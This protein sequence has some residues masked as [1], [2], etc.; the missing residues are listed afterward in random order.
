MAKM[1]TDRMF[2]EIEGLLAIP[3]DKIFDALEAGI[4]PVISSVKNKGKEMG[5]YAT[6]QT[7]SSLKP[8]KPKYDEK[9]GTYKISGEFTGTRKKKNKNG[10]TVR[11]SEVAFINEFGNGYKAARP[12]V[13]EGNAEAA[14][15]AARIISDK[16]YG[17][18]G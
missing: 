16:L 14:D 4:E 5:V 12:F 2:E 1:K 13:A 9:R 7:L 17:G 8:K 6:G 18:K 15:E 3:E 11:N 10:K